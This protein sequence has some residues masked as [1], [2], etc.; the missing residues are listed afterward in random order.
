MASSTVLTVD[1]SEKN[2]ARSLMLAALGVVYGDIGTSPLYTIHQSLVV[3]GVVSEKSILGILSLIAWSLFL[4]VTVKYVIVIMRAD[5]HGEGGLLA[6]TALVLRVIGQSDR[7]RFWV[8]AAGLVG[9]AL[10]YGD[11]I[12]TPAISVL[13]AVEGLNVATP[14]FQPYVVPISLGLL[15]ALFAIQRRGTAAVGG[16]F[17]PI[18]LLWFSV[19]GLLGIANIAEYPRT[20]LALNPSYGIELIAAAPWRGFAMIGAVFLAVTGTETLYA[21]MGHFGRNPLRR[22]WLYFVFPALLLNYFGQGGL[23]LGNP[24]AVDNPFY[25]TV[26][27][28]GLYPLVALASVATIIAS[29]AVISGAFSMTRQA[30]QLGYLPRLSIKHTSQSE[31]GQVYVPMI[32]GAL[33]A[34]IIVLVLGFRTSDSLG[35]AYGIAVS[36]MMVITTGLAF[37]YA[38]RAWHWPLALAV[39]IFSLFA[40]VD[41]T[42]LSANLLKIAQGGWFPVVAAGIVFIIMSTWWRGRR[43]LTDQRGAA[44]IPL[45]DFVA[46]LKPDRYTRISGTAIFLAREIDYAPLALLHALKHYKVLHQR[47]VLMMIETG[48]VPQVP[49]AERLEIRDLGNGFLTIRARFGFM[50]QPNVMGAL[51]QCRQRNLDFKPMETSFVIGRDKLLAGRRPS[52]LSRWRKALFIFMSNNA[53]DATEFFG[54]PINRVVELGAQVEI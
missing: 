40:I 18:M 26:P 46:N 14:L 6:L 48:D 13:S 3:F 19:L 16:L 47:T 2:R 43:V 39:P 34:A 42:F 10:F 38:R 7:R 49:D 54:I 17:G 44:T 29:Q 21:D 27:A 25:R 31:I 32:N 36:G 20:L 53:L 24:A 35:S 4:V 45:V 41:V 50:E 51:A 22:A 30:V 15:I 28:W 52:P 37:F 9:A 8:L 23:L 33:L 1:A 5:N 12:I 11:G